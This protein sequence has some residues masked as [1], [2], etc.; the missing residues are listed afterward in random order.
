MLRFS[1]RV[2]KSWKG[3]ADFSFE[4]PYIKAKKKSERFHNLRNISF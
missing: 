1:K 2:N 4:N 3:K